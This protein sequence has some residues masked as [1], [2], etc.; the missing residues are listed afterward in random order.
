MQFFGAWVS[1]TIDPNCQIITSYAFLQVAVG[2]RLLTRRGKDDSAHLLTSIGS[3]PESPLMV[4]KKSI[5][6]LSRILGKS[7][8]LFCN[9]CLWKSCN[10]NDWGKW[11]QTTDGGF[12]KSGLYI[13]AK[14]SIPV[15]A[16]FGICVS[17]IAAANVVTLV[18]HDANNSPTESIVSSRVLTQC[19]ITFIH[20]NTSRYVY[21][22]IFI[23]RDATH[24]FGIYLCAYNCV[25]MYTKS[26]TKANTNLSWIISLTDLPLKG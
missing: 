17:A 10:S 2:V 1:R 6:N 25:Y 24:E 11:L 9:I 4:V 19:R 12:G 18:A 8:F 7:K 26:Q 16:K 20:R 23:L 22:Y 13:K 14:R 21:K 5:L 15:E 3:L